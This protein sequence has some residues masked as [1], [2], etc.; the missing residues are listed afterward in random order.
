MKKSSH[1]REQ[2]VRMAGRAALAEVCI[3]VAYFLI[4]ILWLRSAK[5][6]SDPFRP[7]DPY[8]AGLEIL[9]ILSAVAFIFIAAAARGTGDRRVYGS[10]AL[11]LAI[12]FAA[13]DSGV[14][15]AQLTV[16]PRTPPPVITW[17]SAPMVVDL[18]A[19]EFLFGSALVCIALATWRQPEW[20]RSLFLAAGLRCIGGTSGPATGH[21]KLHLFATAG[22]AFLFPVACLVLWLRSRRPTT[23]SGTSCA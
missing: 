10:A 7:A 4:G 16:L 15:L 8:L 22:Y 14:H 5:P 6:G 1:G 3:T 23:G 2:Y 17:P 18:I 21:L 20:P 19:W 9:I 13:L 12:V 11:V